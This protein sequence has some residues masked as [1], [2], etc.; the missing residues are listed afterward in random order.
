MVIPPNIQIERNNIRWAHILRE[1]TLDDWGRIHDL[2]ETISECDSGTK[3]HLLANLK[4]LLWI[5]RNT[6]VIYIFIGS[7]LSIILIIMR[8][9]IDT[10][11]SIAMER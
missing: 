3:H 2:R 9:K 1:H 10:E 8:S 11:T 5:N 4:A 6:D 7:M